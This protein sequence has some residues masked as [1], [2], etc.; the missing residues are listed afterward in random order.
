MSYVEK[1][2]KENS[3]DEEASSFFLIEMIAC[4]RMLK[5]DRLRF[6]TSKAVKCYKIAY[7]RIKRMMIDTCAIEI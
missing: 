4:V 7:N 5:L 3:K 2:W 6:Q 1:K